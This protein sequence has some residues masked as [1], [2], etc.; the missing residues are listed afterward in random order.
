MDYTE[1]TV[2][3]TDV[4][5]IA[6]NVALQLRHTKN[7]IHYGLWKDITEEQFD[8]LYQLAQEGMYGDF[9]C[10]AEQMNTRR[11]HRRITERRRERMRKDP[12]FRKR[13]NQQKSESRRRIKMRNKNAMDRKI[14][15]NKTE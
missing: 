7:F 3:L 2:F 15:T 14:Q 11:K 4:F 8:T 5:D 1:T 12:E 10:V 6:P 13:I 9:F